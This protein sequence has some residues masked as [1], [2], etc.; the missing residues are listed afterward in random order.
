MSER[1]MRAMLERVEAENRKFREALERIQQTFHIETAHALAARALHGA[2][3]DQK[4]EGR[5]C[6]SCGQWRSE[7]LSWKRNCD[8]PWH[9]REGEE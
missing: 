4:V 6:P 9:A 8:D 5:K 7:H 2:A 3:L 1:D